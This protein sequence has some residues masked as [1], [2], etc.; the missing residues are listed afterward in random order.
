MWSLDRDIH[1]IPKFWDPLASVSEGR[2]PWFVRMIRPGANISSL[3]DS[4]KE[5]LKYAPCT[6]IRLQV[7]VNELITKHGSTVVCN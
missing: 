5:G 4:A 6:H 2:G 3:T 1:E 7:G